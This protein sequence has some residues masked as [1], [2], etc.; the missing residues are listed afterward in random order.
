M[1]LLIRRFAPARGT[2]LALTHYEMLIQTFS[3]GRR[4]PPPLAASPYHGTNSF[5]NQKKDNDAS[6]GNISPINDSTSNG[7][8]LTS[9]GHS[10][11]G[12]ASNGSSKWK[13][14]NAYA[15]C[16][17]IVTWDGEDARELFEAI[18]CARDSQDRFIQD[19]LIEYILNIPFRNPRPVDIPA[20]VGKPIWAVD[21]HGRAL[22]G[23]PGSET[24]VDVGSLRAGQP[25]SVPGRQG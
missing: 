1:L 10:V 6:I 8:S 12:Y 2:A 21:K 22:V 17:F 16:N 11:N 19:K 18:R 25:V 14:Q 4:L 20:F 3:N 24:I 5:G 15:A 9:N 13:F 23:M 7:H